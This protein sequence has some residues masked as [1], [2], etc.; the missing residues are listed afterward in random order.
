MSCNTCNTTATGSGELPAPS[1]AYLTN[2]VSAAAEPC[3][4][5][6]ETPCAVPV[7]RLRRLVDF[8]PGWLQKLTG[9]TKGKLLIGVG[10]VLHFFQGQNKGFLYFDGQDVSVGDSP[11]IPTLANS[12]AVIERGFLTLAKKVQRPKVLPNG[13]IAMVDYFEHGVQELREIGFGEMLGLTVDPASGFVRADVIEPEVWDLTK[14]GVPDGL[15]RLAYVETLAEG[16]CGQVSSKRFMAVSGAVFAPGE[17]QAEVD[18]ALPVGLVPIGKK[19]CGEWTYGLATVKPELADGIDGGQVGSGDYF[20]PVLKPIYGDSACEGKVTGFETV[21]V[22]TPPTFASDYQPIVAP[23]QDDEDFNGV[24]S[25]L[26]KT[27]LGDGATTTLTDTIDLSELMVIP[28]GAYAVQ[29]SIQTRIIAPATGIAHCKAFSPGTGAAFE[30]LA[31]ISSFSRRTAGGTVINYG[32]GS[33][34]IPVGE[35]LLKFRGTV[36]RCRAYVYVTG[37]YV[38]A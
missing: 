12:E 36:G 10:D 24:P 33:L 2:P 5:P 1:R 27:V 21:Y 17:I 26:I 4:T 11:T 19:S 38:S 9:A 23:D 14:K 30:E 22:K 25:A 16:P 35:V 8:M 7:S 31:A 13:S 28:E 32:S 6:P 20:I 34:E 29:L 15:K 37:F 3:G 18:S